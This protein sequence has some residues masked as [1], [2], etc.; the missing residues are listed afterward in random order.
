MGLFE[1]PFGSCAGS[2]KCLFGQFGAKI[3]PAGFIRVRIYAARRNT[4][5]MPV[6]K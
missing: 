4:G 1:R 5:F 6:L 2:M 3:A